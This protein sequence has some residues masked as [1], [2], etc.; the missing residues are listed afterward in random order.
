MLCS[1]P[2]KLA[3]VAPSPV[4]FALGGA[5]NLWSAWL[6][7][8]NASPG[9]QA[10]LIKLPSP[11]HD[12]WSIVASYRQFA[13][14]DLRHFDRII[15]T[16]YPAWMV[17]HPDHHVYLQHPLRGLYDCW[18]AGLSSAVPAADAPAVRR[19]LTL[20]E[21]AGDARSALPELFAALDALHAARDSLPPALF[22]L[23]GALLRRLVHGFDRIALA[24]CAI[25]S[26]GAISREV[27]G[28]AGYFP[29]AVAAAGEVVVQH[30]PSLRRTASAGSLALPPGA[31]FTASR[32]DGPKRLDLV[33]RAYQ[34][35]QL[36]QPLVIAG[37]G[38][39]RPALAAL[40][41]AGGGDVRLL[42]RL[43]DGDL[44]A[45]YAQ[46]A[47]VVFA[48]ERE[49]YGLI[50]LEALQAG[51]PVLT[52]SD[53]GGVLEL[54]AHERNG[55]VSAPEPAALGAAMRRL[56]TE[57][58]LCERLAGAARA[59][60]AHIQ[61]APLVARYARRLPRLL[62]V[63]TFGALPAASGGQ[64]RLFHLYS[65]LARRADVH[66]VNLDAQATAT[67]HRVLAPGLR[68]TLVPLSEPLRAYERRL[69]E[70]LGASCVDL[71]AASRPELSPDWVAAIAE[72]GR[73]ADAV[74]LSHPYGWPALQ[75]SGVALPAVYEAHNV[76]VDL[77]AALFADASGTDAVSLETSLEAALERPTKRPTKRSPRHPP[78]PWMPWPRSRASRGPVRRQRRRCCAAVPRTRRAWRRATAC[79]H[80]RRWC[81]TASPRTPTRRVSRRPARR[82]GGGWGWRRRSPWR[83]SSAACTGR[84]WPP[85]GRWWRWRGPAR[86]SLSGCSAASA[87]PAPSAPTG[88]C[89]PTCG[90]SGA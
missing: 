61:W 4:P 84:T 50:T 85:P 34:Q 78:R 71:A 17:A 58:G 51:R 47:F 87:M 11:E 79:R 53:S 48:P 14:L 12:F 81:R 89:R 8:L 80:S 72:A 52:C 23:P 43:D 55:L 22:T 40:A 56:A 39:Q 18:P 30:H 24:R 54:V 65:E 77:K 20:L 66:L 75:A 13:A 27:A 9:V 7:A 36:A 69:G 42:G 31:L 15:S 16:K 86:R 28:R 33:I 63:N 37:E 82:P 62:V 60:V 88:R 49:D 45:A 32:L 2:V 74:I 57:P 67:Q 25:R 29:P 70:R 10:E 83:C 1:A 44:E 5:E 64:L 59:S 73:D 35:A 26:Y 76:E 3:L 68:E 21:R 46:A 90:R 41:G 38:P 6:A 19:L